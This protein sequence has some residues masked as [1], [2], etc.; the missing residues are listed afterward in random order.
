[1]RRSQDLK[2]FPASLLN[3]LHS[4]VKSMWE[5]FSN[6][7]GLLRISELFGNVCSQCRMQLTFDKCKVFLLLKCD[8]ILIVCKNILSIFS[9]RIWETKFCTVTL[10]SVLERIWI[11]GSYLSQWLP[12]GERGPPKE[13]KSRWLEIVKKWAYWF[14]GSLALF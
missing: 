8:S 4:N 7:I 1:M 9:I 3:Y 5:I 13:S 6:F 11:K 12:Q 10:H 14:L 2:K